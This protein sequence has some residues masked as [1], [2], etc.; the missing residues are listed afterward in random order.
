MAGVLAAGLISAAGV[1]A[2][3]SEADVPVQEI[4]QAIEGMGHTVFPIGKDNVAYEQYF[5]GKSY[6]APLASGQGIGLSNVTFAPGTINH[7]HIHHKSCQVLVGLSGTGWYQIWGQEPQKMMPGV[8]VTIPEGVKHWH[9][10]A[11]DSWFQHL[12]IMQDGAGTE[13]LEPVD[14]AAYKA[15]K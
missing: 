7:W 10:A 4:T 6:L 15:L 14:E 13:W 8:T 11:P 9:G 2:A 1:E 12:S 5:T 3:A